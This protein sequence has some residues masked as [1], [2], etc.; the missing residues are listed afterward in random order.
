MRKA[1][2]ITYDLE[3][4]AVEVKVIIASRPIDIDELN[5]LQNKRAK[6]LDELAAATLKESL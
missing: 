2:I 6:L 4:I 5:R 3:D 1:Y